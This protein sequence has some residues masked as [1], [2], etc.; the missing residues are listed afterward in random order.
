MPGH[1][2]GSRTQSP[3]AFVELGGEAV[4]NSR[5]DLQGDLDVRGRG[6]GRDTY[7]IVQDELVRAGARAA[8]AAR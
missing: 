4:R 5:G 7:G 1:E 2:R 3:I 8:A 6:G